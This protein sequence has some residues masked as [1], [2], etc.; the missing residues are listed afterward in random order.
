MA[1]QQIQLKNSNGKVFPNPYW[2]VGSIYISVNSTNP[3]TY[4]GGTWQEIQGK[5]LLGRS[6]SYPAGS[7]G[8]EAVHVLTTNEIPIHSHSCGSAGAHTHLLDYRDK[9]NIQ[10]AGRGLN[11]Y[12]TTGSHDQTK[13]GTSSNGAHTH[14]I[15][16]A[17]GGLGH[18][19]MPPYLAVYVWQRTK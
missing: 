6:S 1:N 14:T 12:G 18:N 4:F 10:E 15:G 17:G 7:S 16:N 8:G 13:S 3:S 2:P 19:N 5:F 9:F 11:G